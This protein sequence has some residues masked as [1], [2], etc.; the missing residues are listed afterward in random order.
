[1]PV[2]VLL[3]SCEPGTADG[4]T[5]TAQP[6]DDSVD[7]AAAA[8]VARIG[9][10]TSTATPDSDA[11]AALRDLQLQSAALLAAAQ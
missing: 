5:N 11:E 4:V 10:L 2:L 9:K 1:V 7:A 3:C 8:L 6:A